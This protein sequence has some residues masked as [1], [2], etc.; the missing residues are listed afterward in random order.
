MRGEGSY[1]GSCGRWRHLRSA[2]SY[3]PP[4]M[5][6]HL[7]E[8]SNSGMTKTQGSLCAFVLQASSTSWSAAR[9]IWHNVPVSDPGNRADIHQCPTSHITMSPCEE[10]FVCDGATL[11]SGYLGVAEDWSFL[12]DLNKKL[13]FPIEM[14]HKSWA[15]SCAF[16]NLHD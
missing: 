13:H 15:R 4:T 8:S 5:S 11:T 7:P 10:K 14:E 9:L 3:E 12:V 1:G 2:S 6:S 16:C